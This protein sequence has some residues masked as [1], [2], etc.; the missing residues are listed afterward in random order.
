MGLLGRR[1]LPAFVVAITATTVLVGAASSP[2]QPMAAAGGI[3]VLGDSWSSGHGV[4]LAQTWEEDLGRSLGVPVTVNAISGT[5]YLNTAGQSSG[6]YPDRA[7]AIP[8]N[9]R[10]G[11]VIIQGGSNDVTQNLDDLAGA[12]HATITAV[13]KAMPTTPIVLLGPGIDIEPV[14][15]TYL[16]VDQ[17]LQDI[18]AGNGVPEVSQLDEQWITAAT[19][20][21]VIDPATDHPSVT[22]QAYLTARLEADLTTIL[23]PG[24][25]KHLRLRDPTM[26]WDPRDSH[27]VVSAT[28]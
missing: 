12:I 11:L 1:I 16:R 25:P 13:Q 4:A 17:T 9:T 19:F 27:R 26:P 5:G 7:A 10:A 2:H 14:P 8:P 23:E 24:S 3:Y 20:S 6:T 15:A 28:I 21:S 18:G 22:G